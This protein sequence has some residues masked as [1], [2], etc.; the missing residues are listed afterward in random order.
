MIKAILQ[1]I[2]TDV[3]RHS[4]YLSWECKIH[5]W[6]NLKTYIIVNTIGNYTNQF[7]RISWERKTLLKTY[8]AILKICCLQTE[9]KVTLYNV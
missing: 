5:F 3:L 2:R 7:K 9:N 6:M 1:S 4:V 8:S